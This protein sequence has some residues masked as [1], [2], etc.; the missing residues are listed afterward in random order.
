MQRA[1]A[2]SR[3]T[4]ER[5]SSLILAAICTFVVRIVSTLLL[6]V[7][8][9]LEPIVQT[10]LCA[11]ALLGLGAAVFFRFLVRDP[12]FPF[13][14]MLALSLICTVLLAFYYWLLSILYPGR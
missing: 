2:I 8:V 10:L 6:A 5:A 14:G 13:M 4:G 9:V 11:I 1:P 7:L 12:L 3:R